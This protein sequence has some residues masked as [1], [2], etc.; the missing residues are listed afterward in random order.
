MTRADHL[1]RWER[2][3]AQSYA[4]AGY[5]SQITMPCSSWGIRPAWDFKLNISAASTSHPILWLSNTRDP[6]TPLKNAIKMSKRF[7]GSVVFGQD[8]D[9]HCTV[10]QPSECVAKGVRRYFQEGQLP[11]GE[12]ACKPDVGPFDPLEDEKGLYSELSVAIRRIARGRGW[13]RYPLGI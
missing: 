4:F 12:I 1:E 2:L 8:A 3:K 11:V 10:A 13:G 9:G 7:G 5:W 6:V